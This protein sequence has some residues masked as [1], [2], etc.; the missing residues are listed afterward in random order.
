MI[1]TQ[2][3]C[4]DHISLFTRISS[5]TVEQI[6]HHQQAHALREQDQNS[7]NNIIISGAYQNVNFSCD[8]QDVFIKGI[9]QTITLK[10]NCR[11]ITIHGAG[12]IVFADCVDFIVNH[13]FNNGVYYRKAYRKNKVCQTIEGIGTFAEPYNTRSTRRCY[14]NSKR[15]SQPN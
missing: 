7:K 14:R 3:I 11:F 5:L 9:G 2:I 8:G 12:N 10:G 4:S 13:G 1:T 6:K 15:A